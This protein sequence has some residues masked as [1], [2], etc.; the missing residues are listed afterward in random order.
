[1]NKKT[2]YEKYIKNYKFLF[3]IVSIIFGLC[4]INEYKH[5]DD[6]RNFIVPG[7]SIIDCIE[8]AKTFY[9]TYGSCFF[10]YI[11]SFYINSNHISFFVLCMSVTMYIL[12]ESISKL[13]NVNKEKEKYI[14]IFISFIVLMYPFVDMASAGWIVTSTAY[15]VPCT[16]MITSLIPIKKHIYDESMNLMEKIFISIC[17]A[18]SCQSVQAIC[19]LIG[20]YIC[21][22]IYMVIN[23]KYDKYLFILF[24][25]MIFSLINII[26]CPGNLSRLVIE[27]IKYQPTFEMMSLISKLDVGLFSSLCWLFF[28]ENCFTLLILIEFSILIFCKYKKTEY[29]VLSV[30][31]ILLTILFREYISKNVNINA[32]YLSVKEIGTSNYGLFNV[33][34]IYNIS[35]YITY[36]VFAFLLFLIIIEMILL[37]DNVRD[38]IEVLIVLLF[39]LGSRVGLGFTPNVFASRTRTCIYMSYCIILISIMIYSFNIDFLSKK[40]KKIISTLLL[41]GIFIPLLYLFAYV[42]NYGR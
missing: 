8:K 21:T 10:S 6:I 39:G 25:I 20:C 22:I 2:F 36:F 14:N 33:D 4:F 3:I 28:G 15:F 11:L 18:Y 40:T 30:F 23:K 41:I 35:T 31:P 42:N 37:C 26:V 27:T 29:R 32:F 1:M 24:V 38:L 13:I 7:G 16:L 19:V 5:G 17:V 9:S 12:L 34:S